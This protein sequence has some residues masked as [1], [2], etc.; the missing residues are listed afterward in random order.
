MLSKYY[1]FKDMYANRLKLIHNSIKSLVKTFLSTQQVRLGKLFSFH[2]LFE[3]G[4]CS[5]C[6]FDDLPPDWPWNWFFCA[7]LVLFSRD[8]LENYRC[9]VFLCPQRHVFCCRPLSWADGENAA[10]PRFSFSVRWRL[11][12]FSAFLFFFFAKKKKSSI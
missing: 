11:D 8:L 3:T 10:R 9:T 6:L 7:N 5:F 4:V 1:V 2:F 12:T